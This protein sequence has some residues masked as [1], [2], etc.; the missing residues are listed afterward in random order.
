MNK[1]LYSPFFFF[2]PK[3]IFA[4]VFRCVSVLNPRFRSTLVMQCKR[5]KG[6]RALCERSAPAV[7]W[8]RDL[9]GRRHVTVRFVERDK[10][11]KRKK[12]EIKIKKE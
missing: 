5:L 11:R 12:N 4:C 7:T 9:T 8:A 3:W 6:S 1:D 2:S 10:R